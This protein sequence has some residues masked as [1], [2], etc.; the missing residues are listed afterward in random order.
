MEEEWGRYTHR[1]DVNLE[2][3]EMEREGECDG[4]H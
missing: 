4:S 3:H 1:E 2:D